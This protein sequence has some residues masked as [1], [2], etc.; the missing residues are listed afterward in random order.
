MAD[1]NTIGNPSDWTA[2]LFDASGAAGVATFA[3]YMKPEDIQMI[4]STPATTNLVITQ[5]QNWIK[6]YGKHVVNFVL[7]N[8]HITN[9]VAG[10]LPNA[11]PVAVTEFEKLKTALL[12]WACGGNPS[13]GAG[14]DTPGGHLLTFQAKDVLW[15]G[16]SPHDKYWSQLSTYGNTLSLANDFKTKLIDPIPIFPQPNGDFL[17]KELR[18]NNAIATNS[19]GDA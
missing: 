10:S 19:E 7:K 5:D 13:T 4:Y 6:Q 3:W 14:G 11:N 18:I 9:G 1:T 2:K 15:T 8:I 17:I 12:Y 16:S